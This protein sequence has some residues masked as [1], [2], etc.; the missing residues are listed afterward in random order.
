MQS[1]HE[2]LSGQ[3]FNLLTAICR[4]EL[5]PLCKRWLCRCACGNF[6]VYKPH[7]LKLQ[8]SCGCVKKSQIGNAART[9]GWSSRS[10]YRAWLTMRSRCT[11]PKNADYKRYGG[12]GIK[13]CDRWQVFE[14]FLAD[15]GEC[16]VGLTLDRIETNGNYE[17]GN[18]RWAT[19]HDQH[20]NKS[21]NVNLTFNG[22]TQCCADWANELGLSRN[23]ISKRYRK[24]L[25]VEQILA[26]SSRA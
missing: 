10:Q 26:K 18:C 23:A 15:M 19:N 16:P 11:N 17:P 20:R 12:R 9:H 1:P 5:H 21:S 6:R 8:Q 2:D 22:K 14:N 24:G 4:L 25:P 13:V 3:S 7:H